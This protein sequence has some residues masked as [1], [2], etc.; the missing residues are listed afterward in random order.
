[1]ATK[2][3]KTTVVVPDTPAVIDK[4]QIYVYVPTGS[5]EI[6]GSFKVDGRQF[7]VVDGVLVADM[8][9]LLVLDTPSTEVIEDGG[10]TSAE[11]QFVEQDSSLQRVMKLI[12]KNIKGEVGDKGDKGDTGLAALEYIGDW[13]LVST[14][15]LEQELSLAIELFNRTPLVGEVFNALYIDNTITNIGEFK[16]IAVAE[17]LVRVRLI[18]Y[19][20]ISGKDGID[21][22]DG[23]MYRQ[24]TVLSPIVDHIYS[25]SSF[26]RKPV[27]DE[28]FFVTFQNKDDDYKIYLGWFVVTN[29]HDTGAD[30][31]LISYNT[32]SGENGED[33]ADGAKGEKGDK[34]DT[35]T[36]ISSIDTTAVDGGTKITIGLTDGTSTSF[37]VPNTID[38]SFKVV[39][40][41]PAS[42]IS[43]TTI[44]LL[45]TS[46]SK[47]NNVYDEYMYINGKWEQIGSTSVDLTD[48]AT[49]KFVSD[50]IADSMPVAVTI[51]QPNT[52]VSGTLTEGQLATLQ[53]SDKNY[54]VFDNEIFR[55]MDKNHDSGY[56]TYG[57]LG[58]DTAQMQYAKT[59]TVTVST[60]GWALL[61]N[62]IEGLGESD[63]NELISDY[64]EPKINETNAKFTTYDSQIEDTGVRIDEI[65]SRLESDYDTSA[66]VDRKIAESG[67]KITG[68]ILTLEDYVDPI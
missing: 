18:K 28:Q 33:G 29:V 2:E 32:L 16:V 48:Y 68:V 13:L 26:N 9:K 41:L 35:G 22:K 44:Y 36:S 6:A 59:I 14:S 55:L 52:A 50:S 17:S 64:V 62:A 11:L 53:A 65:E 5:T 47:E 7:K 66:D 45:A 25:M 12:L 27:V 3:Y 46:S 57:H 49:K 61:K 63:V 4:Q 38:T 8:S 1:M 39:D 54:L 19:S 40:Y 43:L 37:V 58:A 10:D 56:L 34:G 60:R 31:K 15:T 30:C 20:V 42:D 67:E 21:G 24:L 23:L 51:N